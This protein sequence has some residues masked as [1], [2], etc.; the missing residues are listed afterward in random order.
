LFYGQES[1]LKKYKIGWI[2]V[3]W[4]GVTLEKVQN[5]LDYH[6]EDAKSAC[7]F[8]IGHTYPLD[9]VYKMLGGLG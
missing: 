4:P 8:P 3:L 7:I 2:F 1:P 6:T 5:R 9:I